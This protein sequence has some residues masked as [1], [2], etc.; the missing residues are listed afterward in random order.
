[1]MDHL[2]KGCD[3]EKMVSL[4][5]RDTRHYAKRQL[6]WFSRDDRVV[7]ISLEDGEVEA[8]GRIQALIQAEMS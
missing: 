3:F 1:M 6:T 8:C 4:W 7:W 2:S 5:K